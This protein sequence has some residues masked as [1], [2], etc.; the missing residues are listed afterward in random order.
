[1]AAVMGFCFLAY[2]SHHLLWLADDASRAT[3]FSMATRHSVQMIYA[4]SPVVVP[5]R[6]ENQ[7]ETLFSYLSGVLLR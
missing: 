3:F 5:N 6:N 4:P 7:Q 1:M 2:R